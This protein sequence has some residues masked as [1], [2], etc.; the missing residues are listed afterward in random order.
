MVYGKIIFALLGAG[1]GMSY[2]NCQ[3]EINHPNLI[4]VSR[5]KKAAVE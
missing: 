5:L 3:N 1:L 4:H 2:S